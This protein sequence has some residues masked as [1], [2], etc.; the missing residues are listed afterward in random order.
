MQM[1]KIDGKDY[2]FDALPKEA[3]S[4]YQ[5]IQFVDAEVG[6][7]NAQIAVCKTARVVYANALNQ[8]LTATPPNPLAQQLAGDTIK[9]G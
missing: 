6:R 7:L 3:R 8:A 9:L 4:H 1:I 2:D 5:G